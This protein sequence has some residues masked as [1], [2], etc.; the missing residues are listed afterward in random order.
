MK[1]WGIW[2]A[3]AMFALA[4]GVALHYS[5]AHDQ[6]QGLRQLRQLTLTTP[7]GAV[8]N[9]SRWQGKVLVVNFWA[10]W[11]EPCR[12]EIPALMRVQDK[13]SAK[14]VQIV[15]IGI[16]DA[17]K[18]NEFV[19]ALHIRYPIAVA[20]LQAVEITRKLGNAVGG[21]PYTLVLD[22]SGGLVASHLGALTEERLDTILR[23]LLAS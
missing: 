6:D 21:L 23:P 16:D 2:L 13:T 7:D 10:T 14:G 15:G 18:I 11:C 9:L 1:R 22:R 8:H 17:A 19:R 4:A 5:I 3:V 20:G 12:E